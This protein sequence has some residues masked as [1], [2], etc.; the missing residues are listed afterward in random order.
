V[1]HRCFGAEPVP[2][3]IVLDPML[4]AIADIGWDQDHAASLAR[5]LGQLPEVDDAAG[6]PLSAPV[7]VV[8][9]ILDFDF[10]DLLV[11]LYERMGGADSGFLFDQDGK[12][13]TVIDHRLKR[14]QDMMIALSELRERI[15]ARIVM[16]LVPA[17]ERFF[18]FRATRMDRYLVSCYDAALGG[19]FFRHR[20]NVNFGARHRRFAVTVNLNRDYDGCDLVFPEFG[21]KRYRA[22]VGGAVVFSCGALHEVTPVTRGRRYAFIPFLYGEEDAALRKANNAHLAA[23]EVPYEGNDD[24]LFPAE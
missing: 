19:H 18:Q 3:T 6:V 15:R 11:G 16:R 20:D 9:R 2:R 17:I 7:L 14:R 21:R 4:R 5:L 24:R 23:G 1:L 8:P 10:C 22:P 13:G 12:T